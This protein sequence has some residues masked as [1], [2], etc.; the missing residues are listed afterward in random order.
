MVYRESGV[1]LKLFGLFRLWVW[2]MLTLDFLSHCSLL[3][4]TENTFSSRASLLAM[5]RSSSIIA[6][7]SICYDFRDCTLHTR[8]V[9]QMA[10]CFTL[11]VALCV[12]YLGVLVGSLIICLVDTTASDAGSSTHDGRGAQ[13]LYMWSGWLF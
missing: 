4:R 7:F 8:V 9:G 12:L 2:L 11:F 13:D 5:V 10:V 6:S 3:I 1:F